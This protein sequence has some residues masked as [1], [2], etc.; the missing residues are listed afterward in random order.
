[1]AEKLIL[2]FEF[3]KSQNAVIDFRRQCI[4]LGTSVRHTEYWITT[5]LP[6]DPRS[7]SYPLTEWIYEPPPLTQ[8]LH[9]LPEAEK[10][11]WNRIISYK[12]IDTK[13]DRVDPKLEPPEIPANTLPFKK[14]A[15]FFNG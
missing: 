14:A 12:E 1:L 6:T 7:P 4:T 13:P 5:P 9:Q 10:S 2:G 8:K 3:L 15:G 11:N